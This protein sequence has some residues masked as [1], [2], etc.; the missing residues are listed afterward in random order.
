[1]KR[2]RGARAGKQGEEEDEGGSEAR[3]T[4]EID[5]VVFAGGRYFYSTV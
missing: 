5:R 1:M 4:E 3:K 2:G